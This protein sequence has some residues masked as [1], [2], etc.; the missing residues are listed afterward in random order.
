MARPGADLHG[1]HEVDIVYQ[2]SGVC[3][4]PRT[5][6]KVTA[7]LIATA[8]FVMGACVLSP[9]AHAQESDSDAATARKHFDRGAEYFYE[10]DNSKA[11]VEFMKAY[12]L[13]PH[14]SILYNVSIAHVRLENVDEAYRVA[15][16]AASMEGMPQKMSTGNDGRIRGLE[17]IM[18]ARTV[19][20]SIV[21]SHDRA[22]PASRAKPVSRAEAPAKDTD[23]MGGLG[24]TG[25]TMTAVGVGL[26][27]YAA[28]T[29]VQLDADISAYQEASANRQV[30]TY[31]Q[32]RQEISDKQDI[33]RVALYSGA[34]LAAVGL[35]LWLTDLLSDSSDD[36]ASV[37]I[38]VN[39]RPAR[40]SIH[41]MVTF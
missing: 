2:H 33:G 11:V 12:R 9:A 17:R 30:A 31:E 7:T 10:G 27:G 19:A 22:E 8:L 40:R 20:E 21:A 18:E 34:G 6:A 1:R 29:H 32:Y 39:P 41:L 28:V 37:S 15:R 13:Q 36:Q 14:P 25:V 3:V 5:L 16:K 24:W 26:L 4:K 23:A 38:G 35:G